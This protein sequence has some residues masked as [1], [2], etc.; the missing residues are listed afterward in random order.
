MGMAGLKLAKDGHNFD[1]WSLGAAAAV[2]IAA[3]LVVS[4]TIIELTAGGGKAGKAGKA[5]GG[6]ASG[7]SAAHGAGSAAPGG[8]LRAL[9]AQEQIASAR[10]R[11]LMP[12]A[13]DLPT[14]EIARLKAWVAAPAGAV[15]V[16]GVQLR[17]RIVTVIARCRM[18]D[19]DHTPWQPRDTVTLEQSD[20]AVPPV[21]AT[22]IQD[23]ALRR[24]L[25]DLFREAPAYKVR[26]FSLPRYDDQIGPDGNFLSTSGSGLSPSLA[27]YLET[28]A[29]NVR[30]DADTAALADRVPDQVWLQSYRYELLPAD[31]LAHA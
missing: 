10:N 11:V 21:T 8:A 7:G 27:A 15:S 1:R 28:R 18:I 17:V 14:A 13:T 9:D 3:V 4:I 2:L 29:R 25:E 24:R 16:A 30:C 26:T 12:I 20:G 23:A 31:F 6:A 5:G 22:T 19:G